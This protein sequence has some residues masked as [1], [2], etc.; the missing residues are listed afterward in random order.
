MRQKRS[1]PIADTVEE[2][3]VDKDSF[4]HSKLTR[5][6]KRIFIKKMVTDTVGYVFAKI[7]S[8]A[9]WHVLTLHRKTV[10]TMSVIPASTAALAAQTIPSSPP[11]PA[12]SPISVRAVQT[13]SSRSKST[14]TN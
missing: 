1:R 2:V 14:R 3:V 11:S 12:T 5:K 10:P 13:G 8:L 9:F 7:A 6:K 4:E